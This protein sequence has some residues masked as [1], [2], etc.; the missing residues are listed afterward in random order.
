MDTSTSKIIIIIIV[1]VKWIEVV[2]TD[3][4]LLL[5]CRQ[6]EYP[7]VILFDKLWLLL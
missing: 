4:Q 2:W 1:K 6:K 7:G 5:E 3:E